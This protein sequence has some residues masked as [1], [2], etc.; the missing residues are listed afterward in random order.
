[1]FLTLNIYFLNQKITFLTINK[2]VYK[3]TL[4][5]V[6]P[7]EKDVIYLLL[8]TSINIFTIISTDFI[9]MEFGISSVYKGND[10]NIGKPVEAALYKDDAWT[11]I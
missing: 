5:E 2:N 4:T 10:E 11:N 7:L 6:L 3:I 9:N 8:S 1:M